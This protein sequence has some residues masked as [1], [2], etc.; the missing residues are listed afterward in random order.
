M[1]TFIAYFCRYTRVTV[2]SA[3]G[4]LPPQHLVRSTGTAMSTTGLHGVRA[5]QRPPSQFACTLAPVGNSSSAPSRECIAT[6]QGQSA[7]AVQ[8]RPPPAPLTNGTVGPNAKCCA[9]LCKAFSPAR[10]APCQSPIAWQS[11]GPN[12]SD[13]KPSSPA[14][15][16]LQ[17]PNT[18]GCGP[19]CRRTARCAR[20]G[21]PPPTDTASVSDPYAPRPTAIGQSGRGPQ[22]CSRRP[23]R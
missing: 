20:C 22:P 10:H 23:A 3:V 5:A 6:R 15:K 1:S 2:L 18:S 14:T 16:S 7:P 17:L 9:G 4:K 13:P 12:P 11:L 19:A 21:R 8:V